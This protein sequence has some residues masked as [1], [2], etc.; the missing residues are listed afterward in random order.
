MDY[1]TQ[2]IKSFSTFLAVATVALV[3]IYIFGGKWN[4]YAENNGVTIELN[5][6]K[7]K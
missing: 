5:F 2:M 7:S 1:I 6:P 3:L 4:Y